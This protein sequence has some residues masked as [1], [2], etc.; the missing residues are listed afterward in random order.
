M[1]CQVNYDHSG[2]KFTDNG[3]LGSK[4]IRINFTSP[5][6]R[7]I[8]QPDAV[9]RTIIRFSSPECDGQTDRRTN[10]RMDR[11]PLA[12]TAVCIASNVNAL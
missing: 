10:G 4:N 8:V 6:T 2:Y 3:I 11:Y 9:N 7:R 5:E 1:I 12:I